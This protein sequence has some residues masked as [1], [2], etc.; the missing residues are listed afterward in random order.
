M[1]RTVA[2]IGI[3]TGGGD[4]PGLNAVI[5]AVAKAALSGGLE[6]TGVEDGYLGLIDGRIRALA[7]ADVSGILTRGGTLS[8]AVR[9][10]SCISER[11]TR[12]SPARVHRTKRSLSCRAMRRGQCIDARSLPGY[13]QAEQRWIRGQ[14]GARSTGSKEARRTGPM[15]VATAAWRSGSARSIGLDG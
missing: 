12:A 7:N 1:T 9:I 11:G 3:L 5:R 8:K 13:L 2:R 4:C 6:V 15:G 14:L 10:A